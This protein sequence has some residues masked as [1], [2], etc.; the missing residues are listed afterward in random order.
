MR[1]N[2]QIA[3][4]SFQHYRMKGKTKQEKGRTLYTVYIIPLQT[5]TTIR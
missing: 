2:G 3:M 1:K 4:R 5:M